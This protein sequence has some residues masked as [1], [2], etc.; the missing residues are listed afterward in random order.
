MPKG[1]YDNHR[2]YGRKLE[3]IAESIN[4]LMRRDYWCAEGDCRVIY[5]GGKRTQPYTCPVAIGIVVIKGKEVWLCGKHFELACDLLQEQLRND[6]N[7]RPFYENRELVQ[8]E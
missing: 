4:L 5:K 1:V 6:I 8:Y 2:G 7:L 3:N